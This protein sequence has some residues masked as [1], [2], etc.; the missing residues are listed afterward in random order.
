MQSLR[1]KNVVS[2]SRKRRTDSKR[3]WISLPENLAAHY[4]GR[5]LRGFPVAVCNT[6]ERIK[7]L[8]RLAAEWV[9]VVAA[10]F[11]VPRANHHFHV[12]ARRKRHVLQ[13]HRSIPRYGCL[14]TANAHGSPPNSW[15]AARQSTR[16]APTGDTNSW[17]RLRQSPVKCVGQTAGYFP[18][19]LGQSPKSPPRP[20]FLPA[21]SGALI[22]SSPERALAMAINDCVIAALGA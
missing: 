21:T 19:L 8:D 17:C 12:L 14:D 16:A 10:T 3:A 11:H 6:S 9:G 7:V 2:V 4:Q 20:D 5:S 13:G 18:L 1:D 22:L 15:A